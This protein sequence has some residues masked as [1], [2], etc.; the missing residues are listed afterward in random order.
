MK[1]IKNIF[2]PNLILNPYKTLIWI[3][4]LLIINNY[5]LKSRFNFN[6]I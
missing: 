2:D 4:N 3:I 5:S 6:A 1:E